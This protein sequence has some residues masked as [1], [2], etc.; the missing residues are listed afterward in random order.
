MSQKL[1]LVADDVEDNRVVAEAIL[2]HAGFA[3]IVAASGAEA[4]ELSRSRLPDLVLLGLMMPDLDGWE[5]MRLLRGDPRTASLP[6]VAYT[7]STSTSEHAFREAGFC[8]LLRKPILPRHL[9][10]A[11]RHC[12]DGVAASQPW[13]DVT[14]ALASAADAGALELA[15]PA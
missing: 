4:V 9:L 14:K 8:A 15:E 6:V 3:V 7:A 13:V 1:L 5:V 12:L 2:R 10:H 11:V